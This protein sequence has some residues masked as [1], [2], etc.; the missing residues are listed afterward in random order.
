MVSGL[1]TSVSRC[2]E[3]FTMPPSLNVIAIGDYAKENDSL[4]AL[5]AGAGVVLRWAASEREYLALV[6]VGPDSPSMVL[7]SAASE[8]CLQTFRSLRA[9]HLGTG[10][11]L[12]GNRMSRELIAQALQAG[13]TTFV[14]L[15]V[16]H[17]DVAGLIH[18]L[19]AV[20]PINLPYANLEIEDLGGEAFYLAASPAMRKIRDQVNTIARTDVTLLI[21]GE[22][23]VG[24]EVLAKLLHR[25][26][27]RS[28]R[29]LLKVN[30]AAL[31][32]DLLESELFGYEAGAFTG[33]MKSKPGKFEICDKGTILLDEIGEMSPQLQAKLLHVLQDGEFSRLGGRGN[34]KADVRIVAATNINITE[35][36]AEHRLREDLYY[37]LSAFVIHIPPLRERPQEIPYFLNEFSNRIA[38]ANH[39][40]PVSFSSRLITASTA[41]PWPGNVRELGNFVKRF[42]IIRDE[43]AALTELESKTAYRSGALVEN[44]ALE[45]SADSQSGLKPAVRAAKDETETQMI[46]DALVQS[47][48]NRR[49]AADR[50]QISYKALLY[51]IRQYELTI[52]A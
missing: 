1:H 12:A 35:A 3:G 42:V 19:A 36:L 43:S 21:T 28:T 22:S 8:N 37:R 47:Q 16:E 51:K 39:L 45:S 38:A 27:L 9:R 20:C 46:R 29:A 25:H 30:C 49:I 23:G 2:F 15:P 34:I 41:Y 31:P 4:E 18:R 32:N 10:F 52:S 40:E 17:N 48:W 6:P 13:L 7:L 44:M 11:A 26:S 14:R 50:L 5:C 24:K 33:A